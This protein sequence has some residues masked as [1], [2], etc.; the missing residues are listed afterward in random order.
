MH[1]CMHT[2]ARD[3]RNTHAS[4]AAST[5]NKAHASRTASTHNKAHAS[6]AAHT[7]ATLV[8]GGATNSRCSQCCSCKWAM[9]ASGAVHTPTDECAPAS[10]SRGLEATRPR[11]S[12]GSQ[13]GDPWTKFQRSLF[14]PII[15]CSNTGDNNLGRALCWKDARLVA[16]ESTSEKRKA[17]TNSFL[18]Q[19]LIENRRRFQ[20]RKRLK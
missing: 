19:D 17:Q 11:P 9:C 7:P 14:N 5:C 18:D 16:S 13:V 8:Q 1:A 4:G 3:V 10:H 6:G 15:L 2:S 20:S 12:S